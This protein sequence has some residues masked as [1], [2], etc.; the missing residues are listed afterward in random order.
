MMLLNSVIWI[1]AAFKK[2]KYVYSR[3]IF[4]CNQLDL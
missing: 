2:L 1:N 4:D 3:H